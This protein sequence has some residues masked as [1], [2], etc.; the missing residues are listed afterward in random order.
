MRTGMVA[1][2][3]G[4][5]TLRF[6]PALPPGWLLL[7][8]PVLALMLLPYRTYP[9]AL[10]LLGLSWACLSAQWALD[11]RLLPRLDGQTLWLQGEVSGL[12]SASEGVV[13]FELRTLTHGVPGCRS[14]SG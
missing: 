3:L 11:D 5:L 7:L 10:W 6:L 1:L 9:L 12:P 14:A 13:R 4:L 2:A 8:M